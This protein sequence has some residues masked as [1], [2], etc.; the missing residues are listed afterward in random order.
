MASKS[1]MLAT[2]RRIAEKYLEGQPLLDVQRRL[3]VEDPAMALL[4]L[5]FV[6]SSFNQPVTAADEG[7]LR[8]VADQLREEAA[9]S[10]PCA[11]GG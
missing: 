4:V 6:S 1:D 3:D 7:L 10:T 8:S 11:A 5:T 2:I 9:R